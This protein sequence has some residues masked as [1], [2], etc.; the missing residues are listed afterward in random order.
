MAR[1]KIQPRPR[2][3][4]REPRS[5]TTRDPNGTTVVETRE[6]PQ[7]V[8][9]AVPHRDRRGRFS[10]GSQKGDSAHIINKL[11]EAPRP[12]AYP[13]ETNGAL[14][15][16][17]SDLDPIRSDNEDNE[18]IQFRTTASLAAR[19]ATM[20]EPRPLVEQLLTQQSPLEPQARQ[21]TDLMGMVSNTTVI[22]PYF[23]EA[24]DLVSG[25]FRI[26]TLKETEQKCA[27]CHE[28]LTDCITCG[29]NSWIWKGCMVC[30]R[31]G[32]IKKENGQPCGCGI[33]HRTGLR[34]S[35]CPDARGD[36]TRCFNGQKQCQ[37]CNGTAIV[38]ISDRR[39][40]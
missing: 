33:C 13:I 15:T 34:K 5:T 21:E 17:V 16:P 4:E 24:G 20:V 30:N 26:R 19:Q 1:V 2:K 31:T 8:P 22:E 3:P 36:H 12:P 14:Q 18:N 6:S 11:S 38:N 28:G 25:R 7:N 23:N 35:R 10:K 37:T 32:S 39:N 29:G 27:H 40:K 9:P